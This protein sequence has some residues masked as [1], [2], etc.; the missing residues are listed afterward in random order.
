MSIFGKIFGGLIW[1]FALIFKGRTGEIIAELEPVGHE[2]VS[3]LMDSEKPG[4]ERFKEAFQKIKEA[5]IEQGIE[6][7]DHAIEMLI[8]FEVTKANDDPLESILDEGLESA[9]EVIQSIN[10]SD[11]AGDAERKAAAIEQLTEKLKSEGKE[12]LLSTRTL[13]L[14]I[15]AAVSSF[16]I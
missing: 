7:A 16:K 4:T 5:A 14:L 15:V 6:T 3:G 8:E 9:R 11:L 10:A 13:N 1:I 2:I 12:W